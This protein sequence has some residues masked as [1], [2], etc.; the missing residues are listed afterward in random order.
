MSEHLP[1]ECLSWEE[2]EEVIFM[3]GQV[4]AKLPVSIVPRP[5]LLAASGPGEQVSALMPCCLAQDPP[6]PGTLLFTSL[7]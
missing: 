2:E 1:S 4:H 6:F 5:Q 7:V 3:N